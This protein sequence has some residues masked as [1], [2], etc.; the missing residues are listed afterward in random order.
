MS[1]ENLC[2]TDLACDLMVHL[3]K[4]DAPIDPSK[5]HHY[6][7]SEFDGSVT[8]FERIF[9]Q[10]LLSVLAPSNLMAQVMLRLIRGIIDDNVHG[11]E[12]CV[13]G[14]PEGKK[15]AIY[16]DRH[17]LSLDE[18]IANLSIIQKDHTRIEEIVPRGTEAKHLLLLG[19]DEDV[20]DDDED[21]IYSKIAQ[22]LDLSE[23]IKQS[24][25][26]ITPKS[27]LRYIKCNGWG[28]D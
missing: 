13:M 14:C 6:F 4:K 11:V 16:E 12:D 9:N 2:Y 18:I 21:D 25:P 28:P 3:I 7:N 27:L 20:N 23:T 15:L 26:I 1:L 24:F 22:M 5:C 10:T 17:E 19:R 8:T